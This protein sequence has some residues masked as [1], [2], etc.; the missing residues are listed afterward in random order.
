MSVC[1]VYLSKELVKACFIYIYNISPLLHKK[2]QWNLSCY[3]KP[4][5]PWP[6]GDSISTNALGDLWGKKAAT[7]STP[8]IKV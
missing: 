3:K 2:E 7:F 4:R 8:I 6:E 5:M 1:V